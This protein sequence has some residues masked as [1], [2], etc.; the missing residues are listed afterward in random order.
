MNNTEDVAI[1]FD[2]I[3]TIELTPEEKKLLND[4]LLELL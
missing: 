1:D 4:N 3:D 2:L